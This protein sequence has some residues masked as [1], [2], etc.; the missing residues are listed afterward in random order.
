MQMPRFLTVC[1]LVVWSL[2]HPMVGYAQSGGT[3][4]G[5]VVDETGGALPGVTVELRSDAP[6][7]AEAVTD[8][9]GG[10]TFTNVAP[11][12]YQVAFTLI[13]FASMTRPNVEVRQ[14]TVRIDVVLHLSLNAEVTVIGR[15]T[16]ANLADVE[17][18][19]ENLVGIA[20]SA[21][22]GAITARQ[23][24]VRPVMRQGEVLETVPGVVITQH[25]GEGKA[26]QYF[27]RGFNLDHGSD[28]AMTVAGTPVNMVTHAHSQG[29]S[30]LN[31]LIPELVAGVQFSKGPYYAEQGDFST[32]GTSN[33]T[34]ATTLDRPLVSLEMGT[35]GY[36]RGLFAASPAMGAGHLLMAVE[37]SNNTGPWANPDSY[38]KYN[39]V[40]RYS[41]GDSV[42]GFV[43]T[44]MGYRGKWNATEAV[45]RRAVEAGTISRFGSEDP[46]DGG[47]TSRYSLATE[48]QRGSNTT[49]TKLT[50]YGIKYDLDLISNFTFLLNDPVHGDQQEQVDDRFV[51]G[52]K[53]SHRRLAKVAGHSAQN[54]FGVQ[55]R[56][57]N[58]MDVALYH[59]EA[60]RRLAA[61]GQASALVTSAGTYA[62]NEMEW[63]PWFRTILGIRGDRSWYRVDDKL[64]AVNTGSA[65]AGL[66]SPKA[67]VTL[68]PWRSTEFYANA[69]M[70]FHS[71]DARGTTVVQDVDG[72]PVDRVTPLVRGRGAEVGFRSVA[73]PHLQSTVSLW[74][75]RL[76]SELV[77]NGDLG[78]TEPGPASR[79]H[80]IEL[81]NYYSPTKWL[82]FD[83]DVSWSRARFAIPDVNGRYVPEAVGVVVSAGASV[84][85]FHRTYGSLR[86]RYFG[87][88]TLIEDNSVR[89]K[90]TT[91]L[92]LDAGYQV[93]KGLRATV[94]VFNLL[95]AAD[96]DIDYFF[97][98]RLPGEPL[99]GVDDIHFHPTPP[100]TV[101]VSGIVS[102]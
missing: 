46:T 89:S 38:S 47:R 71:N 73:I 40:L 69:G 58:V 53:L 23:L 43:L 78:A 86:L 35:Y 94:Q 79:R 6:E 54:T 99:E 22:Q 96:S 74:M 63:A 98:S 84:D 33:I 13:N 60:R 37:K 55:M 27:L 20:Q 21:S 17:N 11:G 61:R 72:N 68:G 49:S 85:G 32:A 26:N 83:G 100:R 50:A 2:L 102:F 77:Y 97:T 70:G 101:R 16:F 34:Y 48:W 1:L 65:N 29:Y 18:P 5:R 66:I 45:P 14:D 42:N 28:F 10:Y 15:R 41:Q 44:F 9:A 64:T 57:D 91:L 51:S 81:A 59:T 3:V 76:G 39:G 56:N 7:P 52:F 82:I 4:T 92:N 67:G 24:D 80:G 31:F 93:F 19:A 12:S 30:D 36:G 95:N 90:Q 8:D 88:R 62:V 25:S 75:L 87:P